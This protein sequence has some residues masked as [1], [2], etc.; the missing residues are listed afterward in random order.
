M[1]KP[2]IIAGLVCL[3]SA[4]VCASTINSSSATVGTTFSGFD[5][6]PEKGT[7]LGGAIAYLPGGDTCTFIT[8]ASNSVCT[9]LNFTITLTPPTANT[10][11]ATWTI[12]NT[13]GN[14]I[15]ELTINL[16]PSN[17]V[18]H[19][20]A[21]KSGNIVQKNCGGSGSS[22]QSVSGGSAITANVTYTNLATDLNTSGAHPYSP[23][24]GQVTFYFG[25]CPG[26]TSFIGQNS[27]FT[28]SGSTDLFAVSTAPEPATYGM[29]GFALAALGAARFY[30]RKRKAATSTAPR[31][32]A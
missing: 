32:A 17:S 30:R 20:C 25:T 19:P 26:C 14:E 27:T 8:V 1:K 2:L 9:G 22:I 29:V 28:F 5:N 10:G 18:F 15:T 6:G 4:V 11:S 23:L 13:S 12:T 3:F 7:D 24:Y 16:Q 21:D 31:Q